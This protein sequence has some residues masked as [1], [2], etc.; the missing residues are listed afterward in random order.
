MESARTAHSALTG[1]A[2]ILAGALTGLLVAGLAGDAVAHRLVPNSPQPLIEATHLSPL[3]TA[4]GD[5]VEL[6]YDVYCASGADDPDID[7]P[8]DASGNVFVR[9]GD[10][11]EFRE[12][13]LQ[14]DRGAPE[15]RYV[16]RLPEDVASSPTGFLYYATFRTAAGGTVTLPA[17]G[18][19]APQQ[20]LPLGRS[21]DIRLGTHRFDS[22]SKADRRVVEIAWG[23]GSGEVGLEQGRNLTPIGGSSFDVSPA[24]T[25]SILDEAHRRLLRWEAGSTAPA[26][27]PLAIN[28][29]L[30]DI[31]TADDGTIYVLES[32]AAP[33]RRPLVREFS[34]D[35]HANASAEIAE[36]AASQIRIGSHGP[37]VLEQ[38][39]GEWMPV[40]EDGKPIAPG[41]QSRRGRVGRPLPRGG[42]V[43]VL[44]RGNEIRAAIV[45]DGSVRRSWRI[46]SDTPIGEVQLAEPLGNRLVLVFRVYT[47]DRDEFVAL[48]LDQ[49][50]VVRRISLDSADWAESAPLSRFRLVGSTLYQL[51][52]TADE[53]FVDRFDLEVK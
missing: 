30:A 16:V 2:G 44:R 13:A 43:V 42:E 48:L 28:G 52:S 25:L 47:R 1:A 32:T 40:V 15:G 12:I 5:A 50:R 11:G 29:T 26:Q 46:T 22:T 23:N 37:V 19:A 45:G 4:T 49:H 27:V 10:S 51:G 39:S 41:P 3:L 33:G 7:V 6:R 18:P 9:S 17:G 36:R 38:P 21:V 20:S 14:A 8:C 53:L 35:G 34:P 31:S 24:G